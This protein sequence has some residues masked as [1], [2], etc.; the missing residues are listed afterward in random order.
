MAG[1][2]VRAGSASG[3]RGPG[4]RAEGGAGLQGRSDLGVGGVELVDRAGHC[5]APVGQ[6]VAEG[7]IATGA[8]VAAASPGKRRRAQ[9]PARLLRLLPGLL[10]DPVGCGRAVAAATRSTTTGESAAA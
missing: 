5:H 3:R 8:A 7:R 2:S 1:V 4:A 10:V 6:A 9:G